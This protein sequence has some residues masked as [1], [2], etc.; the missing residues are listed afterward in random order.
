MECP[1][2]VRFLAKLWLVHFEGHEVGSTP[3]PSA[4]DLPTVFTWPFW[5]N[6]GNQTPSK[7]DAPAEKTF[8]FL[9]GKRFSHP[10]H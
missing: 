5:K 9:S 4:H 6:E 1:N 7:S 3:A 2:K 8:Q 10:S